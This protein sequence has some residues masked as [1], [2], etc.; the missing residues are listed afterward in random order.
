MGG[1]VRFPGQRQGSAGGALLPELLPGVARP[2]VL[3]VLPG[4]LPT[5]WAFAKPAPDRLVVLAQGGGSRVAHRLPARLGA[6]PGLGPGRGLQLAVPPDQGAPRNMD[7]SGS[8]VVVGDRDVAGAQPSVGGEYGRG[9]V[10]I[11]GRKSKLIKL[12]FSKGEVRKIRQRKRIKGRANAKGKNVGV[13]ASFDFY[14]GNV[15]EAPEWMGK[16]GLEWLFRLSQE[17][18]RLWRRY[19][20]LNPRFVWLAALQLLKLK[21]FD[22]SKDAEG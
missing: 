7:F 20:I 1:R 10:R 6:G 12:R 16:F 18:R 2:P 15:K 19:L 9:R 22:K 17:P 11:G 4:L 14:V 5:R 8:P 21:K 13:G 3:V